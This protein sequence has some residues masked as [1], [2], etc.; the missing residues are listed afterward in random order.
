[1]SYFE[2]VICCE[3]ENRDFRKITEKCTHQAVVC[4]ACVNEYI[5]SQIDSKKILEINCPTSG[6]N[7]IMKRYDVKNFATDDV[8]NEYNKS[9]FL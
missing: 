6:C 5:K 8:F 3:S 9:L 4:A 2:C 7:E 1:M